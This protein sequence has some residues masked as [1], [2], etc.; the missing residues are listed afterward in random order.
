MFLEAACTHLS[1]QASSKLSQKSAGWIE[2]H[3][4][5]SGCSWR[6]LAPPILPRQAASK[7]P[8]KGACAGW[9]KSNFAASGCYWRLLA[10]PLPRQ[11]SIKFPKRVQGGWNIT[12]PDQVLEVRLHLP[13]PG[14]L[15][16][17]SKK[18][19]RVDS[20][21]LFFIRVLLEVA[22]TPPAQAS[23]KQISEQGCRV[24]RK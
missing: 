3:F 11:A 10:P 18:G 5:A 9:I 17:N 21:H 19:C 12:L 4:A 22:C 2:N 6:L 15:Q 14:R 20:K 13:C 8:N 23:F 16:T 7:F 1:R 24:N